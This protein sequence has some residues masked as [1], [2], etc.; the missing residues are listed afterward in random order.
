MVEAP[1][2]VSLRTPQLS[3]RRAYFVRPGSGSPACPG[4]LLAPSVTPACHG[5]P[6]ALGNDLRNVLIA[7]PE[8]LA[9]KRAGYCPGCGLAAEPRLTDA[10]DL[11]CFGRRVQPRYL[12]LL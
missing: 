4:R 1:C 7:E 3:L 12:V 11:G 8:V 6:G 10:Q 2:R 9:N 5:R